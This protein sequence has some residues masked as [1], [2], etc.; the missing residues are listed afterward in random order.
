LAPLTS[1]QALKDIVAETGDAAAAGLDGATA[2]AEE[3]DD[4][5]TA[6]GRAAGGAAGGAGAAAA[7]GAEAATTGWEAAVAAL[8]DYATKARDIGGDIGHRRHRPPA[9]RA[10]SGCP[11][12][13]LSHGRAY[14]AGP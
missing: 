9:G 13:G 1:W 7:E 10:H 11:A 6:A 4:A 12:D 14:L 5:V 2:A 8:A 3:F